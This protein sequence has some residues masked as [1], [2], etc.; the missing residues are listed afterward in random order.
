MAKILVFMPSAVAEFTIHESEL[1]E[2][3]Y[4]AER[5]MEMGRGILKI[6]EKDGDKVALIQPA[7]CAALAFIAIPLES[8]ITSARTVGGTAMVILVRALA[9]ALRV[10]GNFVRQLSRV[11]ITLYDITIVLPLLVERLLRNGRAPKARVGRL[12]AG[13]RS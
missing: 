8:F 3:Q 12:E 7:M 11:L 9:V 2:H 4:E 1:S 6:R 5:L 13:E 10:A